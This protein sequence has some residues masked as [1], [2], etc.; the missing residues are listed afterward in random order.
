M[1]NNNLAEI[2][3]N[4]KALPQL[5]T[6]EGGPLWRYSGALPFEKAQWEHTLYNGW[7]KKQSFPTLYKEAGV[8]DKR[9]VVF[10]FLITADISLEEADVLLDTLSVKNQNYHTRRLYPLHFKEGFFRLLLAWNEK[11]TEKI[12]FT[13]AIALYEEYEAEITRRL[14]EAYEKL[15]LEILHFKESGADSPDRQLAEYY[16][17]L[18]EVLWK[19]LRICTHPY[20]LL[21]Q[22]ALQRFIVLLAH[23]KRFLEEAQKP[24]AAGLLDRNSHTR[25]LESRGTRLCME[26]TKQCADMES[27]DAALQ[28]FLEHAVPAMGEAYW[29]A[30]SWLMKK[31]GESG[32]DPGREPFLTKERIFS[33]RNRKAKA[34]RKVPVF[35]PSKKAEEYVLSF[36]ADAKEVKSY[37]QY[38]SANMTVIAELL[39]PAFQG[40]QHI[41]DGKKSDIS[42]TALS[43]LLNQYLL[44]CKGDTGY[45]SQQ[46]Q[47]IPMP[48]YAYKRDTMLRY[49]LACG[50]QSVSEMQMFLALTGCEKFP[51]ENKQ[52]QMAYEALLRKEKDKGSHPI[53]T[54][55]DMQEKRLLALAAESLLQNGKAAV[56][57]RGMEG[58]VKA[59]RKE[60]LYEVPLPDS[61]TERTGFNRQQFLDIYYAISMALAMLL[62]KASHI[63]NTYADTEGIKKQTSQ[64]NKLLQ[65]FSFAFSLKGRA[66]DPY[67]G[68]LLYMDEP[69]HA[70]ENYM[71]YLQDDFALAFP[72]REIS[73]SEEDTDSLKGLLTLLFNR[74]DI[75][76]VGIVSNSSGLKWIYDKAYYVLALLEYLLPEAMSR[77]ETLKQLS[78]AARLRIQLLCII[79]T[80][81]GGCKN[82]CITAYERKYAIN[83]FSKSPKK[84][85]RTEGS[86]FIKYLNTVQADLDIWDDIASDAKIIRECYRYLSSSCP[87]VLYAFSEG[88]ASCEKQMQ[89]IRDILDEMI[90]FLGETADERIMR[91]R[92][93]RVKQ[94]LYIRK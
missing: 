23:A 14:F 73:L 49:M 44:W 36:G 87:D 37:I 15:H 69:E 93:A 85:E 53:E 68:F 17:D 39:S 9:E 91:A 28:H 83:H 38:A 8:Y 25:P 60:L 70:A 78:D 1:K 92:L 56:D 16:D 10:C 62:Q 84:P 5:L 59:Y 42:Q 13:K 81:A 29:R 7:I 34:V 26:V 82:F 51:L 58:A 64:E 11:Q 47:R 45:I 94:E 3:Y 66:A 74:L 61:F 31:Y 33:Y 63:Y 27:W 57:E 80:L 71:E 65:Y 41:F 22:D 40:K 48:F 18:C 20:S 75:F 86:R 4:T 88:V 79:W 54:I 67:G 90:P 32:A 35:E 76:C 89:Q 6:R 77:D 19:E 2:I 72:Y 21:Q 46:A 52:E 12:T 30:F 55:L 50:C 24:S 43:L